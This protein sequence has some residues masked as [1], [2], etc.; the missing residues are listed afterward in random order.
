MFCVEANCATVCLQGTDAIWFF[1]LLE[2]AHVPPH[3]VT[4]MQIICLL[5]K[6]VLREYQQIVN[7]NALLYSFDFVSTNSDF[8][9]N[10][11][12][13][14]SY[15]CLVANMTAEQRIF[16]LCWCGY[17]ACRMLLF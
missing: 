4:F 7:D 6:A 9:T 14:E 2:P 1:Q 11:E 13:G 16:E 8:Y 5:D 15:G 12:R 10:K 3:R 17:V